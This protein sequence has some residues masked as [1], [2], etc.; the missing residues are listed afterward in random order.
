MKLTYKLYIKKSLLISALCLL[1]GV[2]L[3]FVIHP[4]SS[5]LNQSPSSTPDSFMTNVTATKLNKL[6][7]PHYLLI[8]QDVRHYVQNDMTLIQKPF[9]T[10]YPIDEPPWQV[11]SDMSQAIH[12]TEKVWLINHVFIQQLPGNNSHNAT[13][14]T[15]FIT[16]YPDISFAETN[17]P[18]T[19]TQPNTIIHAIG[20]QV[21]MKQSYVKFLSHTQGE[22]GDVP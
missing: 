5:S 16:L 13:L 19:I 22:Y 8:A 3:W 7:K 20:M 15:N 17:Q 9:F 6:G 2:S 11:K 14:S 18:V 1:I 12:G 10:F 21:D 4:S